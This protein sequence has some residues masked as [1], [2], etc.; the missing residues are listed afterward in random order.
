MLDELKRLNYPG[1]KEDLI[2]FLQYIIG[3]NSISL[4]D[5]RVLCS[6]APAGY[7]LRADFLVTY[8]ACFGWIV[9]DEE[10]TTSLEIR[11][12]LNDKERLNRYMVES[13]LST[14]FSNKILFADMFVYDMEKCQVL[15]RNELLPLSYAHIRNVLVS[16]EFFVVEREECKTMFGVHPDFEKI[17]AKFCKKSS[18]ALTLEQLKARLEANSISGAKAEAFVLEYEKRRIHNPLLQKQIKQVSELD[19]CAG[20]DI[21]SYKSDAST[22]YDCFIEVKAISRTLDFYWSKNELEVAMLLGE[23]Y[24][25]YLVD[26]NK[27]HLE[28][29]SPIIIPNPAIAVMKAEDWFVEPQSYHIKYLWKER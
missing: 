6:H 26:L 27:I 2:Y 15:F 12:F 28:N 22:S 5:I 16:Q 21:I 29:Y 14:L 1:R 4:E 25:L 24:Y 20:Y 10:I 18:N 3:N 17:L 23:Q 8:C 13:S 7:Q 9:Q 11:N 19:V